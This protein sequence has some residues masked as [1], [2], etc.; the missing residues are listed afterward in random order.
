MFTEAEF[1][2]SINLFAGLSA[3]EL[4]RLCAQAE[5]I[6]LNTGES[7]FSEGDPSDCVFVIQSG[8]IEIH[9]YSNE[10]PVLLA[11]RGPGE[12]IG[13]LS[14]I[15]DIQ[16]TASARARTPARVVR[17]PRAAFTY[18]LETSPS[19]A[20]ILLDTVIDRLRTND[21]LLR[22][23][24]RMAQLGE[25]TAG[26][27]HELN[28]PA[29]AV[30]RGVEQLAT[31]LAWTRR[32]E[33]N[34]T[35]LGLDD[36]VLRAIDK[37]VDDRFADQH[38]YI[39][40]D[41]I[42]R[43]EQITELE[44]RLE[45]QG[46][47]NSWEVAPELIDMGADLRE[48]E[49]LLPNVSQEVSAA[50]LDWLAA[51]FS[52]RSILKGIQQGTDQISEII[53]ALKTYTYLD[54]APSQWVDIHEGL[55]NTLILLRHEWKAGITIHRQYAPGLP[56]VLAYG[57]EL[58]QV[59]TNILANAID[60]MDG[61]GQITITT[62]TQAGWVVVEIEDNGPGI[63]PEIQPRVFDMYYTSK[64][65]GKGTGLGMNLSYRI[66]QKHHGELTFETAPGRTR[67]IARLPVDFTITSNQ[68]E[69]SDRSNQ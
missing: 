28:N 33:Q 42:S 66:I 15:E 38:L 24:E 10:Q 65:P 25:L 6:T 54:Q 21:L 61:K 35:R 59:W 22:Q 44:E 34:A 32:S 49:S 20:R 64:P 4:D 48:L 56:R 36:Q 55:D 31:A 58:N 7:L 69:I 62:S 16:R 51:H 46:V 40:Q 26:I 8:E 13:E 57:S 47:S 23:S 1:L 12:L 45:S 53:R 19:A 68:G 29:A 37:M 11:V 43:A 17:L 3:D 41:P 9:K 39:A 27:A 2:K 30:R 50:A 14:L 60:A 67:F 5:A 52:V 63:P 18:L